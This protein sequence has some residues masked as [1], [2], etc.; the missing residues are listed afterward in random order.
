[1]MRLLPL[2]KPGTVRVDTASHLEVYSLDESYIRQYKAWLANHGIPDAKV[3]ASLVSYNEGNRT[4]TADLVLTQ[5]TESSVF[6][7]LGRNLPLWVATRIV[8]SILSA[9]AESN[10]KL[11][12]TRLL[13][14]FHEQ[15]VL[16]AGMGFELDEEALGTLNTWAVEYSEVTQTSAVEIRNIRDAFSLTAGLEFPPFWD[17]AACREKGGV[18]A[19]YRLG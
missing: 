16:Y 13:D 11:V 4:R 5:P 2:F 6:F 19:H 9:C 8:S 3:L 7:Y 10:I 17:W 18:A 14:D 12:Q 1:M 15:D